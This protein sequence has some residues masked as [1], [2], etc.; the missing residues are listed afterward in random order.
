M[1]TGS[2]TEAYHESPWC[3]PSPQD[4]PAQPDEMTEQYE[5]DNMYPLT[6]VV[7]EAIVGHIF[8]DR[9]TFTGLQEGHQGHRGVIK[10]FHFITASPRPAGMQAGAFGIFKNGKSISLFQPSRLY[11][12]FYS[13]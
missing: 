2:L 4:F 6:A 9:E 10:W 3:M 5:G 7:G 11:P 13:Q 12:S 8:L 1:N